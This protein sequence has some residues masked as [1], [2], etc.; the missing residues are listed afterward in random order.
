MKQWNATLPGFSAEAALIPTEHFF[1]AH[2][3]ARQLGPVR[4][5]MSAERKERV[6][7]WLHNRCE[8]G[9]AGSCRT[10]LAHCR[11]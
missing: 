10:Y 8:E 2:S 5:Q 9:Q 4:P 7:G 11:S 3:D 6:C 1:A